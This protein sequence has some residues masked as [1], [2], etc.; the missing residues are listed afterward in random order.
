MKYQNVLLLLVLTLLTLP[1]SAKA[2]KPSLQ[3]MIDAADDGDTLIVSPGS[4]T[5]NITI[6]KP[7]TLIGEH[8][9]TIQ[10]CKNAPVLT[11]KGE[12][13]QLS[14]I[15]IEQCNKNDEGSPA[16]YVTGRN[17][18][19]TNLIINTEQIG[20][21]LN[22]ANQIRIE[23]STLTGNRKHNSIDLWAS[24]NNVIT[25]L[26]INNVLDGIYLEQSNSN[27]I[28]NN[29]IQNA[30]YG[31]H[32]MF[33]DYVLVE[34]N[35]SQHNFAGAMVMQAKETFIKDNEFSFN[36]QN[37][38]SQGLLLYQTNNT[39]VTDNMFT[40]NRIGSFI[41]ETSGAQFNNNTFESNTIGIQMKRAFNNR[42]SENIFNGNVNDAQAIESA[43]NLI[44]HNYWDTSLKLDINGDSISEI[45]HAA[46]PY[47]LT[48]IQWVPE[49][50]LFFQHP[51]ITLLKQVFNSPTE[52]LLMDYH[53]SMNSGIINSHQKE[54]KQISLWFLGVF[55][56]IF[57]L[58]F[59]QKWRRF[60]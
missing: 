21:Q 14:N 2:D 35:H 52:T 17:H 39:I 53:P 40:S 9:A 41:E 4:Y 43:D 25:S 26:Q 7:V 51:G 56:T 31:I 49:Y 48:L 60:S 16:I 54:D 13:V 20:I 15:T 11:I 32:L 46:D 1:I 55:F 37:V 36:N 45:P 59:I 18:V 34:K 50:Q 57:N 5:E 10:S 23:K 28:T 12:H 47:F 44:E 8:K 6:T 33:S 19:L 3:E 27:E 29:F 42:L 58:Y 30:R 38:N 24:S 22:E